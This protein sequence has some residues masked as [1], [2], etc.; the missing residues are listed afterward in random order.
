MKHIIFIL[1][2]LFTLSLQAQDLKSLFIALPD[3]LSPLLTKVNREDFGDFLASNMKAEVRNRFGRTSEMKTL[4]DNYLFLQSSSASTVEMK[5]LP[6][7]DSTQIIC[8]VQT[9][10]A[11]AAD[12][13]ISFY[14]TSWKELPNKQFIQLPDENQFYKPTENST[15]ADSLKN[16]RT[17]ADMYLLKAELSEQAPTLS[18]S[19]TTPDYMDKETARK[20]SPY[21]HNKPIIYRWENGKFTFSEN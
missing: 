9:Y 20:L 14:D 7:N 15:Q 4:T 19:Y 17:S 2:A 5:L 10:M 13:K 16:L 18:F 1:F 21:L 6:L 8:V 3:S 11:P 12:S